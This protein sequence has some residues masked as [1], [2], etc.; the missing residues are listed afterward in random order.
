[1][2]GTG[3]RRMLGAILF[4]AVLGLA[5][6]GPPAQAEADSRSECGRRAD[7]SACSQQAPCREGNRS[8]PCHDCYYEPDD[9]PPP[10]SD[11]YEGDRYDCYDRCDDR[12]RDDGRAAGDDGYADDDDDDKKKDDKDDKKKD[13]K[14]DKDGSRLGRVIREIFD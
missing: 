7:R 8:S 6:L 1:M 12:W 13:E 10:C 2:M 3:R 14:K 4:G 11:C 5:G 9:R